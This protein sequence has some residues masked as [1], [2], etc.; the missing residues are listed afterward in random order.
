MTIDEI[1]AALGIT[2]AQLRRICE[3]LADELGARVEALCERLANTS[4]P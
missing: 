3:S 1:A 4:P 2:T